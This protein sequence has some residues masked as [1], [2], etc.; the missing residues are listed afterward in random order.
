LYY[1]DEFLFSVGE[2]VIAP[3]EKKKPVKNPPKLQEI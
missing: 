3:P 1:K 2:T